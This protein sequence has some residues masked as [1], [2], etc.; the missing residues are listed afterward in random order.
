MAEFRI[1]VIGLN[2]GRH[3]VRTLANME[4]V[5]LVAVA[6]RVMAERG[7]LAPFAQKY[8]AAGYADAVEMLRSE[9]LDAVSICVPPHV[10]PPLVEYAA[11]HG[12]P[13]LI[14]KPWSADLADGGRLAEIC[15][16]EQATVMLGFS[17]RYLPAIT[18][19]RALLDGELGA[20]WLLN[21]EY[22]FDWQPPPA[23]WLWNPQAGNGFF[24]ENSCH[25]IDAVCYLL[26]EPESV[27][28]ESATH[29]GS[30]SAEVA[31][32]TLRFAG[33][34]AAALTLGCLGTAAFQHFPR[35]DLVTE[36]GQAHLGG[37]QHIWE[38]LAWATRADTEIHEFTAPPE[39][40]GATR[41]TAALTHFVECVR[42]GRHPTAGIAD[43][44]RAVAVAMAIDE[45]GRTGRRVPVHS[46]KE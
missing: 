19:L 32:V 7:E 39:M 33:G 31:A 36:N 25:L 45:S 37:R 41:Y 3:H 10:R 4:E 11:H 2:F 6:D 28:A 8:G 18:R 34:A 27:F 42:S 12:I 29:R 9:R 44:M 23:H 15:R 38:T 40:L 35:L 21:G 5:T 30:P 22:L 16:R 24:N 26:G 1:G 46:V 17:F 13:M 20:G 14:E 43:G